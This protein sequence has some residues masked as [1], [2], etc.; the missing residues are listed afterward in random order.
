MLATKLSNKSSKR[1]RF[2]FAQFLKLLVLVFVTIVITSYGVLSVQAT[3][4]Y[5]INPARDLGSA[6]PT[7]YDLSYENVSFPSAAEDKLTLSA[8][9]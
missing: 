9:F 2:S 1:K 3:Y 6:S 4:H 5:T 7:Q 8:W